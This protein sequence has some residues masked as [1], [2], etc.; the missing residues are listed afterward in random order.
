MLVGEHAGRF[1]LLLVNMADTKIKMRRYVPL[2][3]VAWQRCISPYSFA[4][5]PP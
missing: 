4:G 2:L 5:S 3:A 1:G